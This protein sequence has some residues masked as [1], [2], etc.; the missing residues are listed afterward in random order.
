[1]ILPWMEYGSI[2]RYIGQLRRQGELSDGDWGE[3][4]HLWVC[5]VLP[6]TRIGMLM[7]SSALPNR[8]GY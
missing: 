5:S 4:V 1:M 2:L 6:R 7:L 8:Y 3:A